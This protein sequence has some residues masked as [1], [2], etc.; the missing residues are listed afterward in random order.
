LNVDLI[1]IF[2]YTKKEKGKQ[3]NC[4]IKQFDAPSFAVV[5]CA[6]RYL[7]TFFIMDVASTV[8]FQALAYFITGEVRENGAYSVLGLLR[9]WRLR[10]VNQFFTRLEKDIRFSYFWIRCARLV[11]VGSICDRA[12]PNSDD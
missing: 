11:A 5:R 1:D 10:R 2:F 8:P 9:L 6:C 7:S 4:F 3:N 12:I